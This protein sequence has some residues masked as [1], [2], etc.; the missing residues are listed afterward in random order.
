MK[1]KTKPKTKLQK[2]SKISIKLSHQGN[3]LLT[4]MKVGQIAAWQ[5]KY[6]LRY[7]EGWVNL[8]NPEENWIL[9]N[10]PFFGERCFILPIGSELTILIDK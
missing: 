5:G 1:T 2:K 6:L 4:D 9:H 8:D 3:E 7:Y 10:S